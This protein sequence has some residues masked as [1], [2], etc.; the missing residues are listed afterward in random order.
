MIFNSLSLS[1]K[2]QYTDR[3]V[4]HEKVNE[5]TKIPKFPEFPKTF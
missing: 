5:L 4:R 2:N 1:Y 3:D